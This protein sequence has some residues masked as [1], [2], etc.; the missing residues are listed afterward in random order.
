MENP[1][2]SRD[3]RQPAASLLLLPVL[4]CLSASFAVCIGVLAFTFS[5]EVP[6]SIG[7]SGAVLGVGAAL[8]WWVAPRLGS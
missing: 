1:T 5:R 6:T 8:S 3:E 7:I 2:V 4:L